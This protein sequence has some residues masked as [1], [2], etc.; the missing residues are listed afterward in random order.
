MKTIKQVDITPVWV[1]FMPD[2]LEEG[3]VYISERFQVSVHSC[4]C[5]CGVKTVPPLTAGHWTLIVK[6]EKVSFSPSI[7]NYQFP[8]KSHYIITNNKANFV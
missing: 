8:C 4:L 1:E 5:G 7:A 6:N 2:V 3:K